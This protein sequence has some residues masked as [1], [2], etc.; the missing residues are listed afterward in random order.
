V[1]VLLLL[2]PGKEKGFATKE[3]SKGECGSE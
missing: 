2:L 3:G 1:G